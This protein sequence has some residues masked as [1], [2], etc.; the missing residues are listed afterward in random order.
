M[1]FDEAREL[2]IKE[3]SRIKT[4]KNVC[5]TQNEVKN[6]LKI[7]FFYRENYIAE[8]LLFGYKKQSRL[9]VNIDEKEI[10]RLPFLCKDF[11]SNIL[12]LQQE[13]GRHYVF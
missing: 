13:I 5:V 12:K 11:V 1:L 2:I 7:N 9:E 6:F 4:I 3:A 8:V 10:K